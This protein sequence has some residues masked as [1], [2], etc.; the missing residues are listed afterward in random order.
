MINYWILGFHFFLKQPQKIPP[1]AGKVRHDPTRTEIVLVPME[2]CSVIFVGLHLSSSQLHWVKGVQSCCDW[3]R[4]DLVG[5]L[6]KRLEFLGLKRRT[7][8]Y[9]F[10]T[11]PPFR[12]AKAPGTTCHGILNTKPLVGWSIRKSPEKARFLVISSIIFGG[13]VHYLRLLFQPPW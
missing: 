11:R 1:A 6:Q 3:S 13:R 8:R 12:I 2:S 10:Q 5:T 7:Q 9:P 4:I